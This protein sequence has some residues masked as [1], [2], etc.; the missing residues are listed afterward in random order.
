MKN[1]YSK[2]VSITFS[3]TAHLFLQKVL[4]VFQIMTLRPD[5]GQPYIHGSEPAAGRPSQNQG[6]Q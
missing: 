1:Q 2:D 4:E 3:L 5:C 6:L